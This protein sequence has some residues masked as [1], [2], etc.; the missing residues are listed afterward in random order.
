MNFDLFSATSES[1][2]QKHLDAAKNVCIHHLKKTIDQ[3]FPLKFLFFADNWKSIR[4]NRF[5]HLL[6]SRL[7]P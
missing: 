1:L 3:N 2:K 5:L 4:P 7:S 6:P